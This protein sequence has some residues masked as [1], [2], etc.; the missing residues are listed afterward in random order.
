MNEQDSLIADLAA[1]IET[2]NALEVPSHSTPQA[3]PQGNQTTVQKESDSLIEGLL[4]EPEEDKKDDDTP[5]DPATAT[6]D[7]KAKEDGENQTPPADD[8]DEVKIEADTTNWSELAKK[9]GISEEVAAK[10]TDKRSYVDAVSFRANV[11]EVLWD[12]EQY[13]RYAWYVETNEVER[14]RQTLTQEMALR[15]FVDMN[16]DEE[17]K[18]LT[19]K[20]NAKMAKW[21]NPDDTTKLNAA[22]RAQDSAF[23]KDVEDKARQQATHLMQKFEESKKTLAT[24]EAN[25]KTILE[26]GELAKLTPGETKMILD[27]I[28]LRDVERKAKLENGVKDIKSYAENALWGNP[29]IRAKLI[30]AIIKEAKVSDTTEMISKY[31]R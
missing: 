15:N 1:E 30:K 25:A 19:E 6:P 17:V 5:K 16:D 4:N 3:T 20:V 14:V 23:H 18:E 2:Q 7:D 9:E 31:L 11:E 13:R 27:E 29:K 8:E 12:T 26:S 28:F 21:V 10:I 24:A 22:G